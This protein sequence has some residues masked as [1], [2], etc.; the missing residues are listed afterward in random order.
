MPE[1]LSFLYSLHLLDLTSSS[2]YSLS[3]SG[4]RLSNRLREGFPPPKRSRMI[5]NLLFKPDVMTMGACLEQSWE[6]VRNGEGSGLMLCVYGRLNP[7]M[8]VCACNCF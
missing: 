2:S 1:E 5:E 4:V 6:V 7:N 3:V 8:C